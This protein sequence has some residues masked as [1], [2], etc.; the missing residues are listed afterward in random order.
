MTARFY[1]NMNHPHK[2]DDTAICN[3]SYIVLP[4]I[5]KA[6]S[7]LSSTIYTKQKQWKLFCKI[8]NFP[9]NYFSKL[10]Q[11]QYQF[12]SLLS[13]VHKSL[14]EEIPLLAMDSNRHFPIHQ[15]VCSSCPSANAIK[16][17]PPAFRFQFCPP[18]IFVAVL[19]KDQQFENLFPFWSA[20]GAAL[21]ELL[22][23]D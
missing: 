5:T 12:L 8:K 11:S 20:S 9:R 18:S 17:L 21:W 23:S 19:G 16:L 1:T 4:M 14:K 13:S 6:A 15:E 2:P 22:F 10:K 7:I 3:K